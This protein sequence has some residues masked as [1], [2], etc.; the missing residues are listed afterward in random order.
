MIRNI[1]ATAAVAAMMFSPAAAQSVG[2]IISIDTTLANVRS[3]PGTSYPVQGQLPENTL[4][5][6]A[7]TSDGWVRLSDPL[8]RGVATGWIN[9]SLVEV[10][11]NTQT[12][13]ST[14]QPAP[15]PAPRRAPVPSFPRYPSPVAITDT[16]FDCDE[17]LFDGGYNSCALEVEVS[18]QIPS[19][20]SPFMKDYVDINCKAE[21]SYQRAEEFM[22]STEREDETESIYLYGAYSTGTVEIDFD[23]GFGFEPVVSA[24]VI[25]L[26]CAPY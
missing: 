3:G 19:E 21:L 26:E 23:F 8:N 12:T 2:D 18:I 24:R 20:Y 14:A 1:L 10:R 25:D 22:A 7:E 6:V 5:A 4:M 9:A 13:T 15:A 11:R 16:D 17:D